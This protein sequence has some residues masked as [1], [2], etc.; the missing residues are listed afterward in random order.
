MSGSRPLTNADAEYDALLAALSQ[1]ER[2]RS[3]LR[4]HVRRNR[5]GETRALLDAVSRLES[6]VARERTRPELDRIRANLVEMAQAIQRTKAD[7]AAVRAP[8]DVRLENPLVAATEAL[9]D[10]VHTTEQATSEILEAAE[11]VQESAWT[12]R[13]AGV[14]SRICD[15]LDR[16][17]TAIYTACSFQD[18]TAQRTRKV[19]HTLRFLEKR[20]DALIDVW[21]EP[22]NDVE[23]AAMLAEHD[24]DLSQTDV[25][26]LVADEAAL[27]HFRSPDFSAARK[28]ASASGNSVV[29]DAFAAIDALSTREK[30]LKFT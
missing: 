27:E 12:L 11:H 1:S 13:E 2:G 5:A 15:D 4:E 28:A 30:L 24:P 19:V 23:P 20:I 22:G 26:R 21:R 17:A 10:I 18:L 3:F 8:E 9:D 25:D 14:Q 6:A 7:I 29:A 16:R